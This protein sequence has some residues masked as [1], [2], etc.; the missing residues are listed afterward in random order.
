MYRIGTEYIVYPKKK[1]LF[2]IVFGIII[3]Y[4]FSLIPI[5]SLL[6]FLKFLTFKINLFQINTEMI[7]YRLFFFIYFN[8]MK[9]TSQKEKRKK[10]Y[11]K[12]IL[13]TNG[14]LILWRNMYLIKY[15]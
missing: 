15:T 10:N 14:Y 2:W 11:M 7:M 8:Y 3:I 13:Y 1:Y 5:Y 6:A 12:Y 9:Y 4:S